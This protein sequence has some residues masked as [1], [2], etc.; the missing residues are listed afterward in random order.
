MCEH[1]F[2]VRTFR[3]LGVFLSRLMLRVQILGEVQMFSFCF[4]KWML[5]YVVLESSIFP[6]FGGHVWC[7]YLQGACVYVEN[8]LEETKKYA[9][10]GN[11]RNVSVPPRG[12]CQVW[13]NVKFA[14]A[15]LMQHPSLTTMYGL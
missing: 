14:R 8:A 5:E 4:I 9:V 12:L 7:I 10:R 11:L 13:L 2:A 6:F 1:V 3:V 15:H